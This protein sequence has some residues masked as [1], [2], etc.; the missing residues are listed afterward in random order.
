MKLLRI[1]QCAYS[2]RAQHTRSTDLVLFGDFV[3]IEER[4]LECA[5]HEVD[6]GGAIRVEAGQHQ[7]QRRHLLHDRLTRP[8]HRDAMSD[9]PTDRDAVIKRVVAI[10]GDTL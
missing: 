7:Q 5:E 6:G 9:Q 4:L 8:T 3:V 10:S 1:V 2:E